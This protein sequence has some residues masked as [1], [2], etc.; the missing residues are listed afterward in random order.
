[1][2]VVL[3]SSAIL[4]HL[5]NE[6]GEDVVA[7]ATASDSAMSSVNLAEVMARLVRNGASPKNAGDVLAA[8]P[9]TI[10]AFDEALA[11]QT[12]AMVAVTRK[13]GLSLGDRACLALARRENLPVLT[14]DRAWVDA[15]PVVGV[16]VKLIR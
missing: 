2:S 3:D 1:V 14:A 11:L 8:L 9:V 10:H 7:R 12:G 4:A 5:L 15:G 13:F 6:P 16:T